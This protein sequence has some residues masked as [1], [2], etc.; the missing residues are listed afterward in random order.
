MD[1]RTGSPSRVQYL[2][3]PMF[4]SLSSS[5]KKSLSSSMTSLSSSMTSISIW[6][7][8]I[9]KCD[10]IINSR[11]ASRA[12]SFPTMK[13]CC[14]REE[15]PPS[16]SSS[17]SS[18][19]RRGLIGSS[20]MGSSLSTAL[21]FN[22]PLHSIASGGATAGGAYLLR[23]KS[24]WVYTRRYYPLPSLFCYYFSLL[25]PLSCAVTIT[26]YDD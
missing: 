26:V 16:V 15:R 25:R 23:A 4:V 13:S 8:L 24:R 22:F 7:L 5:R 17:S 18:Y 3:V 11:A 21:V 10:A 12:L 20:L 9:L 19:T 1:I 2:Q 14:R 6:C